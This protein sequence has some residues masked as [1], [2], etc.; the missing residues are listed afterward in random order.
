MDKI[1]DGTQER[2]KVLEVIQLA[3]QYYDEFAAALTEN[4]RTAQGKFVPYEA[5]SAKDVVG[6]ITFWNM[7]TALRLEAVAKGNPAPEFEED[8]VVNDREYQRRQEWTW[9]EIWAE[10]TAALD[11]LATCVTTMTDEAVAT[12]YDNRT[13]A[14][15]IFGSTISHASSH[16]ADYWLAQGNLS[17]AETLH[18]HTVDI[19]GQS[20][21][22][23]ARL[24][25]IYNLACF[26]ART[27]QKD[28]ALAL[29]PDVFT[30]LPNFTGLG[31]E[32]C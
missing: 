27:G 8:N 14:A 2:T 11:R 1:Q 25:A 9:E 26:Y 17:Q 12:S 3:R 30:G 13:A 20:R 21:G 6:H 5:W 29:L 31:E 15:H 28:R 22:E 16:F 4:Q 10:T 32:R 23:Q 18:Q 19:S 24:T 7:A